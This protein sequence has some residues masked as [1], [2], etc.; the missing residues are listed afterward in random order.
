M[1][2]R[3][4]NK[5]VPVTAND[6]SIARQNE[7]SELV[8]NEIASEVNSLKSGVTEAKNAHG[9]DL[10]DI[11]MALGIDLNGKEINESKSMIL[12]AI[13]GKPEEKRNS[14]QKK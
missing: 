1:E 5:C 11:G 3:K 8:K 6:V 14:T 2:E 10:I 4:F 7:V 9:R 13:Q 12:K